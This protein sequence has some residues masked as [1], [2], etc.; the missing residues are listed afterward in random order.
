MPTYV[1]KCTLCGHNFEK[2]QRISEPPLGHCPQ[3]SGPVNR[4]I[5]PVGVIFRGTG[6][7]VT[8]NKSGNRVNGT[9]PDKTPKTDPKATADQK[10][11]KSES[12]P[13]TKATTKESSGKG[14]AASD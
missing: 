8:D 6:F 13:E 9:S 10:P 14:A 2:R 4:V 12:T 7:Y 1:Y 5:T 11:D 3:C